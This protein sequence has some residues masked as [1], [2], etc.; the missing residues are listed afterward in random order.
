MRNWEVREPGQALA[1]ITDCTL[2]TVCNLAGKKSASKSEF[3]RQKSIAQQAITW[4]Q[5]MQV[6]FSKT[7]AEDV[8]KAGG[9]EAWAEQFMPKK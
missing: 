5:Q 4:M 6:D 3:Q 2:A 1:Y 7:R 8:V 9:V